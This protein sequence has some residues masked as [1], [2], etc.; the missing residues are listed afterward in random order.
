M[1]ESCEMPEFYSETRHT[2][3]KVH[4]CCECHF[5]INVGTPYIACRGKWDGN[6]DVYKQH[7]ECYDLCRYLNLVEY[8]DCII[9]FTQMLE[10]VRESLQDAKVCDQATAVTCLQLKLIEDKYAPKPSQWLRE[11]LTYN[12][13]EIDPLL[14]SWLRTDTWPFPVNPVDV[15][16]SLRNRKAQCPML[17]KERGVVCLESSIT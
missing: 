9:M 10:H 8:M 11:L 5:S 16:R 1:N 13:D 15:T 6:L 17:N 7:E 2:A 12:N 14:D 3:K 4:R